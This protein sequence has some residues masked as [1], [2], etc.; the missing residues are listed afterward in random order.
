MIGGLVSIQARVR[1]LQ[2][3]V[4]QRPMPQVAGAAGPGASGAAGG[5]T[6]A[7]GV[8]GADGAGAFDELITKLRDAAGGAQAPTGTDK[9][10]SGRSRTELADQVISTAKKY[11]GV[12]YLWG[13][14]NPEKGL[15]C[16]GLVQLVYKKV[17]VDLPRVSRDQARAGTEVAALKDARP[18]DLLFFHTPVSHV[19]IYLGNGKMLDAPKTGD[20][21]K[22]QDV[23][24][25]PSHIRR[26]LPQDSAAGAATGAAAGVAVGAGA[27]PVAGSSLAGR[28][29]GLAGP[30][31]DLFS[32]AGSKY[33]VDPALLS[34]V[35]KN[36]S[37]YRA[38]AVS[39]AGARGLMQIM[40]ATARGLGVD[41]LD[42][43]QAVDG[44]ARLLS[45]YLK[46][47]DGDVKLS[48]AAYN[49]GPGAVKRY[50][51]VP[52]YSE[53]RTYI[54]RVTSTWKDLR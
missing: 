45:G 54:E 30:F 21:V 10:G 43:K 28:T 27:G 7:G 34:A 51:G 14:T 33:G 6:A 35:A 41:P 15:D 18:G 53:T 8:A 47:Y 46:T 32:A 12:P 20:V 23:W 1:E 17:G 29:G 24:A 36:E 31:A 40:P 26:V 11:L 4:G 25:T 5:A 50:G 42:P 9:A 19:G 48:L 2:T 38:N 22:I 39:P 49:A 3:L 13:G 16:S 44:A 52:P 37:A